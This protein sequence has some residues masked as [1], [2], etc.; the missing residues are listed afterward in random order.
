M[1]CKLLDKGATVK[2][3]QEALKALGKK[4]LALIIHSNS[5]PAEIDQ[6]TG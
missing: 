1:S 6:D 5:F 2:T 4:N 3:I